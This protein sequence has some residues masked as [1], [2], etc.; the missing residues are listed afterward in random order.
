[1][2]YIER[3]IDKNTVERMYANGCSVMFH[4]RDQAI[5]ENVT[6]DPTDG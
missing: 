4:W 1:M 3:R 2:S 6:S 5:P